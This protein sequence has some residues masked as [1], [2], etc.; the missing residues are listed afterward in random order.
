MAKTKRR[1]LTC[2]KVV[3]CLKTMGKKKIRK[4]TMYQV[5]DES[6]TSYMLKDDSE[7]MVWWAKELFEEEC[8][9]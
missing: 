8:N 1:K 5:F 3:K 7:S 2:C 6:K 9:E 4:N